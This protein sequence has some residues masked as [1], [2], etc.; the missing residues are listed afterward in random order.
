[1]GVFRGG[2]CNYRCRHG[3]RGRERRSGFGEEPGEAPPAELPGPP[4]NGGAPPIEGKIHRS[5]ANRWDLQENQAVPGPP[6]PPGPPPRREGEM[7]SYVIS[8]VRYIS[9]PVPLPSEPSRLLQC[10]STLI[11]CPMATD[12]AT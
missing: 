5:R 12:A 8:D 2:D 11:T 6:G 9:E 1:M 4:A 7:R 10:Y 3:G